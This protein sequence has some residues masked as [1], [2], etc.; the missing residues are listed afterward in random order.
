[1]LRRMNRWDELI[2]G[3]RAD[4][5]RAL[6]CDA[7]A[8]AHTEN[9]SRHDPE[10]LG[11]D[12]LIYGICTTHNARHVAA[13]SV[14]DSDLEDVAVCERGRVWWLE[15]QRPEGAAVR[16]YFYKAPPGGH[17]VWDVR[18][19]DAEIKKELSSSN[20][21]QMELFNRSGGNGN[22]QLL[23]LIVVH[24]GDAVTGLDK[25]D[26]GAPYVTADGIA[27]DWYERFDS[28]APSASETARA[29]SPSL[30]DDGVGFAGL[31]LAT[32]PDSDDQHAADGRDSQPAAKAEPE[33]ATSE[34]EAL[35]LREDVDKNGTDAGMGEEPS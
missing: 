3:P 29:A 16:V 23:N 17:T 10:D 32:T 21:R 1:M 6:L 11:D 8:I 2:T 35:G 34:F 7:A 19:D 31:R 9:G 25:L 24:Y 15:I 30:G 13:R 4:A 18:L 12:A 14:E 33:S 26:V 5:L 27:W 28:V 22:A 20:G